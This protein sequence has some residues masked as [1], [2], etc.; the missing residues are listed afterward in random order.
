M[1][2]L[3][4]SLA[5][6]LALLLA[7]GVRAAVVAEPEPPD[8]PYIITEPYPVAH[9]ESFTL[10]VEMYVP[11]GWTVQYQW[12]TYSNDSVYV[13]IPNATDAT[14]YLSPGDPDYPN[15]TDWPWRDKRI[16][17]QCTITSQDENGE[18]FHLTCGETVCVKAGMIWRTI[19]L[20]LEFFESAFIVLLSP[21]WFPV[22]FVMLIFGLRGY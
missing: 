14:L 22:F 4:K 19:G 16:S 20:I 2:H 9:G 13:D 3:K 15:Y 6:V 10:R 18:S 7:F 11:E 1:K 21:L 12:Q 17:Y 5:A 8:K